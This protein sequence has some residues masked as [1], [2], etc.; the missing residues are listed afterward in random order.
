MSYTFKWDTN[1][2]IANWKKHRV[3]FTE[4]MQIFFDDLSSTI[5]DEEHSDSEKRFV[6]IG[7]SKRNRILVVSHTEEESEIRIISARVA[8]KREKQ[9]YQEHG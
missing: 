8:S 3:T 5:A 9:Q 2:A 6:T 4:A 7:E 1:K